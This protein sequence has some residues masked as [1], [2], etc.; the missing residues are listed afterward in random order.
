MPVQI[1]QFSELVLRQRFGG[2]QIQR[3]GIRVFDNCVQDRQVVAQRL[4]GSRRRDDDHILPGMHDF[5]RLGLVRVQPAYALG[6]VCME[7]IGVAPSRL[8][9][10]FTYF[11][12]PGASDERITLFL[13]I[14]DATAVPDRAGA[15]RQP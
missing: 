8:T 1:V 9:E 14:V 2:K 11:P 5:R 6:A 10:L 13:G 3:A 7:E 4:T 12:T 15:A